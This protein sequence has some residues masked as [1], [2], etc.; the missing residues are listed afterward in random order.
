MGCCL[1]L[2]GVGAAGAAA[3]KP[4]EGWVNLGPTSFPSLLKVPPS[5]QSQKCA[6]VVISHPRSQDTVRL[7][8]SSSM[9]IFT[10]ALL[11]GGF[12]VLL[13]HDGGPATWGSKAGLSAAAKTHASAVR[14]FP[15]NGKTYALGLSMG[16]LMSL[17]SALPGSPYQVHGVALIDAWVNLTDAWATSLVRRQEIQAAYGVAGRPTPAIDPLAAASRISA[18]LFVVASRDDRTA[19]SNTNAEALLS[20]APGRKEVVWLSGPHMGGNRF[21]PQ[22]A[23][24]LVAFFKE[25]N[26]GG[27]AQK[28]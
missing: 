9:N 1:G 26:G 28:P 20:A 5:C 13:S 27:L 18:P 6:L 24:R 16:G 2:V 3:A 10:A 19:P 11:R 7:M 14:R 4:T 23:N 8:S 22:L 25:L 12:A 17:R 21:T 15:W